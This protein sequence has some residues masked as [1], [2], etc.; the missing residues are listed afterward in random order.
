MST[1]SGD[2]DGAR[3]VGIVEESARFKKLSSGGTKMKM[4]RQQ[5]GGMSGAGG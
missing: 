1:V 5:A 3:N 2:A 4:W